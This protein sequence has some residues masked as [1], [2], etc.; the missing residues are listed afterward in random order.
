[1]ALLN[2]GALLSSAAPNVES[3]EECI[4][5]VVDYLG[6][7]KIRDDVKDRLET[8]RRDYETEE[9]A[10]GYRTYFYP[11]GCQYLHEQV[12]SMKSNVPCYY[13]QS[14]MGFDERSNMMDV[15]KADERAKYVIEAE[16]ACFNSQ[17]TGSIMRLDGL[18]EA[19]TG[20]VWEGPQSEKAN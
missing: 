10:T 18:Y 20:R 14:V 13:K 16:Y 7:L 11:E 4:K 12:K 1:M 15:I 6:Q 3:R 17:A 9:F 19:I 2:R 5:Q 8:A